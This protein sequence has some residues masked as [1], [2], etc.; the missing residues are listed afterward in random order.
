MQWICCIIALAPDLQS[1]CW[2]PSFS[3][4][5]ACTAP[6]CQP[7]GKW[8]HWTGYCADT[9]APIQA[10]FNFTQASN[11]WSVTGGFRST[12]SLVEDFPTAVPG[13]GLSRLLQLPSGSWES[14]SC[15]VHLCHSIPLAILHWGLSLHT[16]WIG[17]EM[18][19]SATFFAGR[20]KPG[21]GILLERLSIWGIW[22]R[23]LC[24][25]I[26]RA[27]PFPQDFDEVFDCP[28]LLLR[29]SPTLRASHTSRILLLL[30]RGSLGHCHW[31][32]GVK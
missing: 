10:C 18:A 4:M 17:Q 21:Y 14:Q 5:L 7:S 28:R 20:K 15:C 3:H 12:G 11:W 6:T 1:G 16:S 13:E 26:K 22:R 9:T 32:L 2:H 31:A 25:D 27:P 29:L 30:T 19:L 8:P 24:P 23:P